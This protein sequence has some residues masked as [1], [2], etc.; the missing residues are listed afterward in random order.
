MSLLGGEERPLGVTGMGCS[1]QQRSMP[2]PCRSSPLGA[3]CLHSPHI[4]GWGRQKMCLPRCTWFGC[5]KK[6][7]VESQGQMFIF[8]FCM[9]EQESLF[10]ALLFPGRQE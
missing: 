4:G 7:K 9:N 1:L 5:L 2:P 3:F 10:A 6:A 8:E